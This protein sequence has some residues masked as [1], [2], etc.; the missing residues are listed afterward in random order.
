MEA[1]AL[2]TVVGQLCRVISGCTQLLRLRDVIG[3]R[4]ERALSAMSERGSPVLLAAVEAY[5]ADQNLEVRYFARNRRVTSSRFFF[6][7]GAYR[8]CV[9]L[10]TVPVPR[11]V[12]SVF[13]GAAL[14]PVT[15]FF[16]VVCFVAQK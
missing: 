4:E 11:G 9:R 13:M 15:F 7:C 16:F 10:G 1:A 6:F 3:E 2:K 14:T 12:S 8:A 5:G